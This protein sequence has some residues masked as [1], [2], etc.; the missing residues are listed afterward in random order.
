MASN[1][2]AILPIDKVCGICGTN[3]GMLFKC[4]R[5]KSVMYCSKECQVQDWQLHKAYCKALAGPQSSG[6]PVY[7][8]KD[9]PG[10]IETHKALFPA[11]I[12]PVKENA[13]DAN[14]IKYQY[15]G[16]MVKDLP[17]ATH[18]ESVE[19]PI[20]TA[21]GFSLSMIEYPHG[22]LPHPNVAASLLRTDCNPVS[23]TFAPASPH[24]PLGGVLLARRD[25]KHML[26]LH[27]VALLDY[28]RFEMTEFFGLRAREARGGESGSTG[29]G[30]PIFD[31][32][33]IC[34]RP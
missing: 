9:L 19:L 10:R 31:S 23:T 27:A 14:E 17:D 21:L 22:R 32:S 7:E 28:L 13:S 1:N 16:A 20:T 34:E 5:C 2:D 29:A 11:I 8:L 18:P 15:S 30:Q 24:V 3:R 25:G 33:T 4:G 6:N 26:A 12:V